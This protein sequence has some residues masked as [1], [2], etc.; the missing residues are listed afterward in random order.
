MQLYIMIRDQHKYNNHNVSGLLFFKIDPISLQSKL[1]HCTLILSQ[2]HRP[3][4]R[5]SIKFYKTYKN[6]T[7][8]HKTFTLQNNVWSFNPNHQIYFH[9]I[10]CLQKSILNVITILTLLNFN[11]FVLATWKLIRHN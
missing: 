8:L 4:H 1:F 10:K 3:L 9:N 5:V 11:T 7:F 2:Q 6:Q